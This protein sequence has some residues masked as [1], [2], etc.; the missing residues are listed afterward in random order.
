MGSDIA[1]ELFDYLCLRTALEQM[2][3]SPADLEPAQVEQVQR[4]AQRQYLL[5]EK[6]L[7]A[8]PAH[9]VV[10]PD[11][12]VERAFRIIAERY[13]TPDEFAQDLQ[14]NGLAPESLRHSLAREL[15]VEATMERVI[16]GHDEV[17]DEEVADYYET[18]PE[19][20]TRPEKRNV[21]HILITINP[22]LPD[23]DREKAAARIRAIAD[24]LAQ[25]PEKFAELAEGNSECVTA[26]KGGHLG[27]VPRETLF[28]ELDAVLFE[29]EAGSIS[30][31]V[32]SELGFHIL[33]CD[34]IQPA[35]KFP[36]EEMA[37]KIREA[38]QQ[39]RRTAILRQWL[40]AK[41][42]A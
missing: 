22:E 14:R 31:P 6:V 33:H 21:H 17:T 25:A 24:Q 18:H 7:A 10:V 30:E 19:K 41:A 11:E 36:F 16:D 1:P 8:S 26:F 42:P 20:F 29:M 23:N 27:T 13:E 39:A 4:Q 35:V 12:M 15:K 9:G 28:P 34:E 40:G 3:K 5:E 32:E 2:G 38:L 37:P